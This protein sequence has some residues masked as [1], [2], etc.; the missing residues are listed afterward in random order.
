MKFCTSSLASLSLFTSAVGFGSSRFRS[1]PVSWLARRMFWPPRPMACRE[2]S[3]RTRRCPCCASP[4]PT[5]MDMTS[6]GG[7]GVDSRNC[8]RI[9]DVRD[10][11]DALAPRSRWR[12]PARASRASRTQA[13]TGSMR[14]VVALHRDLGAARPD[15]APRPGFWMRPCPTSGDLELE[16]LDQEL[17]RGYG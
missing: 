13:P 17:G 4:R 8:G 1:H 5:T 14:G 10:D 2:L 3:P 9:V 7:H 16:E 6:A 11:V 12:P 15:R